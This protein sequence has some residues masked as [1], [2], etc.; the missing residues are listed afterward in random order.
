MNIN[1]NSIFYFIQFLIFCKCTDEN[2]KKNQT[3]NRR[4]SS[5]STKWV[6]RFTGN[7]FYSICYRVIKQS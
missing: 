5:I 3:L 7:L 6:T 1:T 2:L 4:K